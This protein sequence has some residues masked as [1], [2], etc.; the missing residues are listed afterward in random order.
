M[1]QFEASPTHQVHRDLLLLLL[2][3]LLQVRKQVLLS[4]WG[5]LISFPSIQVL[6]GLSDRFAGNIGRS[7]RLVF[8]TFELDLVKV[9]LGLL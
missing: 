7:D 9:D 3:L 1:N 6:L 8:G 4:S 2:G 5:R